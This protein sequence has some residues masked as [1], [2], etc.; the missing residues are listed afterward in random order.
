MGDQND[1][2]D[3]SNGEGDDYLALINNLAVFVLKLNDFI[4]LH[5]FVPFNLFK[6]LWLMLDANS[7]SIKNVCC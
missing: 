7:V 5:G 2:D 4:L 3:E 6:T 1:D